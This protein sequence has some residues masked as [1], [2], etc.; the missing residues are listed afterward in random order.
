MKLEKGYVTTGPLIVLV[1]GSR[2]C[3]D[4]S[5]VILKE[6]RKLALEYEISHFIHGGARGADTIA[7][8]IAENMG[9]QVKVV[10]AEWKKYGPAA[11]P[12]R[13]AKMLKDNPDLVLA[14]PHFSYQNKGTE[15]MLK[16]AREKG[17][18]TRVIMAD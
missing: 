15:N 5:G 18:E 2:Y 14:F 6:M 3:E 10:H 1:C 13:N 4:K 16:Q 11:G 12:I 7:G 9:F 8:K 17:I